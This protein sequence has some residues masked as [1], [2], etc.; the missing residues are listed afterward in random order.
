M[1]SWFRKSASKILCMKVSKSPKCQSAERGAS[2]TTCY[3]QNDDIR[4][5]A[6]VLIYMPIEGVLFQVLCTE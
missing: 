5:T 2:A 3:T 4:E 6:N 1:R